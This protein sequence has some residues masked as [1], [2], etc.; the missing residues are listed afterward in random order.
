MAV[1]CCLPE[2]DGIE[3]EQGRPNVADHAE[4]EAIAAAGVEP[5]PGGLL[6]L[7]ARGRPC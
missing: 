5:L 1:F 7:G 6:Y 2:S 3:T 4:A